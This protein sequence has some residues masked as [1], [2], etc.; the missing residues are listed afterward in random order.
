M[1]HQAQKG[2]CSIYV[3]IPQEQN[4]YLVYVPSTRKIISSYDVVFTERFFSALAYMLQH[5]AESIDM[6]LVVSYTPYAACLF[7]TEVVMD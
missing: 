1:R 3:G 5:Y 2:L 4:G 7:F 6:R